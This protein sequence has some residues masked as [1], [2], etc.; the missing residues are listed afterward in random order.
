MT[1]DDITSAIDEFAN[2]AALAVQ[3]GG[4]DGVEIHGANG[5]LIDQ[6]LNPSSNLRNDGYGGSAQGK[7]I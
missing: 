4:F 6:F 1:I 3:S 5:Y 7:S 2:S